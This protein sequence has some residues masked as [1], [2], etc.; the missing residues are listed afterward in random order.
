MPEIDIVRNHRTQTWQSPDCQASFSVG[1]TRY[2]ACRFD[3]W[4]AAG[5]KYG[6]VTDR[7]LC[8]EYV[9]GGELALA[10]P[11]SPARKCREGHR[12]YR[13]CAHARETAPVA[14]RRT[15]PAD[16]GCPSSWPFW[17]GWCFTGSSICRPAP[18]LGWTTSKACLEV[19]P[20]SHWPGFALRQ[21]DVLQSYMA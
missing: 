9:N 14:A 2:I 12:Y 7:L 16:R 8:L 17:A 21:A 5:S 4:G 6:Q 19:W 18:T 13:L 11:P 1:N 20:E 3:G 10:G 15:V